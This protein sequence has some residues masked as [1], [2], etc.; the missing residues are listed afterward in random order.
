MRHVEGET[1][2]RE[3][4]IDEWDELGIPVDDGAEPE[5]AEVDDDV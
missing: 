2:E 5:D 1:M 3:D 4:L